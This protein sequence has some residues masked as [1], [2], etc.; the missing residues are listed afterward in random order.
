MY[1]RIVTALL[2]AAL[3]CS[4]AMG[5]QALGPAGLSL[6]DGSTELLSFNAGTY[7]YTVQPDT[8]TTALTLTAD[9]TNAVVYANGGTGVVGGNGVYSVNLA[10]IGSATVITGCG[11]KP[12]V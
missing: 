10:P 5:A 7:Q 3:V 8:W 4:L 9:D 6:M 12:S 2:T 1:K 11:L